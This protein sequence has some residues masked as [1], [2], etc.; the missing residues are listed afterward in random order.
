IRYS[1]FSRL[2][3]YE[4]AGV[5]HGLFR[6]RVFSQ[7]DG[8]VFCTDD[9]IQDE[10]LSLINDIFKVY[11]QFGFEDI[12]LRLATMPEKRIGTD[13]AWE[14][15]TSKLARALDA[16]GRPYNMALGEG[17]FYGPKIE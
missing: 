1:E 12:E 10:S 16:T 8:H 17:A 4:R 7:D 14:E 2:H 13:Q 6:A 3:R 15:A 5:T 9:Q 11:N